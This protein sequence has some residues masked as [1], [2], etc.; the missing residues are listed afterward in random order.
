MRF[1]SAPWIG[2][3]ESGAWL[4]NARHANDCA[5]ALAAGIAGR[6]DVELMFPVQSNAVFVK[7][8]AAVIE[9]LRGRG[10]RFYT[11]IGGGARF[12]FA[13]DSDPAEIAQLIGDFQDAT[14][15]AM[16]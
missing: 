11:F 5:T 10:W 7:A 4:R 14:A 15:L 13:W 12:M 1:L 2:L 6:P 9:A 8:P 16:A 3:L